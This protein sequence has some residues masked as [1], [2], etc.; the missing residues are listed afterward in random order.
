MA[1]RRAARARGRGSRRDRSNRSNVRRRR[2]TGGDPKTRKLR[3]AAA[4]R[5]RRGARGGRGRRGRRRPFS[6]RLAKARLT[7]VSRLT[8]AK[9]KGASRVRGLRVARQPTTP[10]QVRG[11]GQEGTRVEKRFIDGKQGFVLF[12]PRKEFTSGRGGQGF[13][14]TQPRINQGFV[15]RRGG[16]PFIEQPEIQKVSGSVQD[17]AF[18]FAKDNP[19]ILI[20]GAIGLLLLLKR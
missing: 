6:E 10:V 16:D 12:R 19:I 13:G 4:A 11:R 3:A 1:R 2:G 9:R 15:P 7:K 14:R 20:G 5:A 17:Q 18:G 8:R